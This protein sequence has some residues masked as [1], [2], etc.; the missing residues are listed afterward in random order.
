MER[1]GLPERQPR[2]ELERE[3]LAERSAPWHAARRIW[4]AEALQFLFDPRYVGLDERL[5]LRPLDREQLAR[6]LQLLLVRRR[7]PGERAV[8]LAR[9]RVGPLGDGD[10][11]RTAAR[12][13]PP[14]AAEF[15]EDRVQP[16]LQRAGVGVQRTRRRG[17]RVE[18]LD[19]RV[20]TGARAA[21][22]FERSRDVAPQR[23]QLFLKLPPC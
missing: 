15:H 18:R 20:Q 11:N 12:P 13:E 1:E 9:D 6:N 22:K 23:L 19:D 4:R 14:L 8:Q 17:R 7:L 10:R 5:Q 21:G 16:P 2:R 3:A